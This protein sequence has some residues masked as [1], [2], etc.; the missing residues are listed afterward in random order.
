[1][2]ELKGEKALNGAVTP[3]IHGARCSNPGC[4]L[5]LSGARFQSSLP[6]PDFIGGPKR[7]PDGAP[8]VTSQNAVSGQLQIHRLIERLSREAR[9]TLRRAKLR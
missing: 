9:I 5:E 2:R 1:M 8:V 6:T 7:S 4:V 3:Q